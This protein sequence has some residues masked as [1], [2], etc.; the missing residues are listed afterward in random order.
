[1]SDT[2]DPAAYPAVHHIGIVVGRDFD[3]QTALAE[4]LVENTVITPLH[5]G[6]WS[7][8]GKYRTLRVSVRVESRGELDDLDAK[9]R[10]VVG[11]IML[12]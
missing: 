5:D 3:G 9:L 12:L 2:S 1:M 11:V 10:A 4:A 8:Q 6:Q 7:R